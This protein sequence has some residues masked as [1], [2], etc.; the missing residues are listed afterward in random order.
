[1]PIDR[2][3]FVASLAG[4]AVFPLATRA[5]PADAPQVLLAQVADPGIDPSGYLVSEKYDGARALWDG[6]T[7]RFRSG[8]EV[9]APTWFT[10]R[11]P[12]SAL[13]GELWLARGRFD[14][15]SGL[16]RK[17]E[18]V[19]AEWRELRY[20]V[21][22]LPGGAGSFARRVDALRAV[23]EASG[24]APL[25]MVQQSR[26][27]DRAALRRK[28]DEVVRGGGE[29]LM[30]HRADAPYVTGRSD[31]LLKM[32]PLR[33]EE[34][35]VVAHVAGRG[36]YA[37][38]MGA[39]ELQAAN[40]QRFRVGTGFSD[41]MRHDP[42]ALRSTVT[43]TYRDRTPAGLPRFASYLRMSNGL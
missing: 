39:L 42:P 25:Q 37:G 8:R 4:G 14:A 41:E 23:V 20:M 27:A 10:R 5:R 3:R 1:M 43:Y 19:D 6:R 26:L 38:M 13:D 36:K 31:V 15:L 18:P 16:V 22:E 11:L 9:H 24:F 29:G 28:L 17:T 7:L 30:L 35:I 21:F 2:R 33:D 34:A 32:K 40:G 12:A